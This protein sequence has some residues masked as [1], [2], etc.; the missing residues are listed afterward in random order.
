MQSNTLGWVCGFKSTLVNHGDIDAL[1]FQ[2]TVSSL[3]KSIPKCNKKIVL[4]QQFFIHSDKRRHKETLETLAINAHNENIDEIHLINERSYTSDELGTNN[5]KIRQIIDGGKRL[6]YRQAMKYAMERL[7]NSI[8][9]LSNSDIFFDSTIR[10]CRLID[11]S[12]SIICLS[13]YKLN[14]KNLE[15]A[16]PEILNGWSQDT[17]IWDSDTSFSSRELGVCDF[18]LGKPGCDN[19][20]VRLVSD[21]GIKVYNIPNV[22]KGYHH[23][24]SEIRNYSRT[25]IILPQR[26]LAI[27]PPVVTMPTLTSFLPANDMQV[28]CDF[29]DSSGIPCVVN[30]GQEDMVLLRRGFLSLNNPGLTID[31]KDVKQFIKQSNFVLIDI[32]FYLQNHQRNKMRVEFAMN[33]QWLNIREKALDSRCLDLCISKRHNFLQYTHRSIIIVTCRGDLLRDRIDSGNCRFTS[34]V[35]VI[36][37][38]V[39][40]VSNT[41]KSI[42][43]SHTNNKIVILDT[44]ADL[45]FGTLLSRCHI[46]SIAIGPSLNSYFNVLDREHAAKLV[47]SYELEANK[48]WMFV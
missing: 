33:A 39:S 7:H 36:N 40:E 35:E 1:P 22:I 31:I 34:T 41:I 5:K 45:V 6:T 16:S 27:I 43:I 25:D 10:S 26:Y 21:M 13:R 38:N 47:D 19:R 15:A 46:P 32:P 28:L 12:Q 14:G 8:V 20:I 18:H 3:P 17:W 24:S 23:H 44:G 30:A 48:T 4:I 29:H 9:V 11:L 42:V 37:A 2:T